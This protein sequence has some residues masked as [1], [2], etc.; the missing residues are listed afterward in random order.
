MGWRVSTPIIESESMFIKRVEI[1][2]GHSQK[3][4]KKR[5]RLDVGKYCFSNRVWDEW[6]SL[7]GEIVNAGSLNSC[8]GRLVWIGLVR[9]WSGASED[10]N[11]LL[12]NF[13]SRYRTVDMEYCPCHSSRYNRYND[14]NSFDSNDEVIN[15]ADIKEDSIRSPDYY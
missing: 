7:P 11:K 14:N 1:S 12:K 4:F 8:K 5:V 15:S 13:F 9:D 6:N 10:L 3:Q 2:R